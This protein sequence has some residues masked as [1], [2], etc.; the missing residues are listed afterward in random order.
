MAESQEKKELLGLTLNELEEY[1]RS[2]NE[3]KFRAS[4]IF[5]WI[6]QKD[7]CSF[8]EMS[9]LPKYFR[10]KLDDI[11]VISIP[12]VLRQRVSIDGTRKFLLELKDKKK[13]ET[14][15]IPHSLEK[16][17][18]YT[19]CIS[20]QVGCPIGC[21]FCAT[22][23]S[24]FQRNLLAHEI[25]GQVL[26]SRKEII[27]RLKVCDSNII[28]NVVYMGMGEPLI[29]YDE[30]IKS[31]YL[32]NDYKGINIGQRNITVSTAGEAEGIEKLSQENLQITL[33]ISL[34]AS[35]N[36]LR[37]TLIPLNK[38]YPLEILF[39]A[40]NKYI[41]NTNRRVTFEYI[42]IDDINISRN[43]A[44]HMIQ[45]LKPLMANINLIAYNEVSGLEYK[46]P[47]NKKIQ[48]F[49]N[50]LKNAGLNVSL[51]EERGADIEAACGQ[52]SAKERW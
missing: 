30:F 40:I 41:E 19:L 36:E 23:N 16:N 26:G 32:L 22:G 48:Y 15:L 45:V 47:S 27:K 17:T 11:A 20:S 25:I 21:S 24:G 34:H 46:K 2:I 10:K 4:Q 38:K 1:I 8:Y 3:N 44:N 18:R 43:D 49:Y 12:R 29:N 37:N 31:I 13:V 6:Y 5:K 35:N 9:D 51:R 52:L 14:V 39:K 33:A 7:V 28:T 50:Y 42:M